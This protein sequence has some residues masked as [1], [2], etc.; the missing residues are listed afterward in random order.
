[1]C[2]YLHGPRQGGTYY[3]RMSIPE[4]LRP[5]IGKREFFFS[6]GTKDRAEAKRLI[7]QVEAPRHTAL[8]ERAEAE[9]ARQRQV[10]PV[11]DS[12]FGM[13]QEEFEQWQEHQ[14]EEYRL[15]SDEDDRMAEAE[16][17]AA[18]LPADHNAALLLREE[19]ERGDRYQERYRRRKRRDQQRDAVPTLSAPQPSP[20]QQ[21]APAPATGTMLDTTVID[22]WAT[23]RKV[24][25]K[26]IDTH[27][28]VARWLYERVGKIP[29]ADITRAH[30]IAFKD[31]LLEE[32]QSVPNINMKLSRL[33]TLLQWAA[34][35]DLAPSNAGH[36]ISIKGAAAAGNKRLPFDQTD[37]QA[38]FSS[39]VFTEGAR[40]TPGRGE[41]V[42]WL[43][44]LAL[45]SGARMEELG[46]L[47]PSD[48]Q[49]LSYPDA[50]GV[51]HSAW[52]LRITTLAD[53]GGSANQ[54]K[55]QE[56]ER[57][58]PVHPEIARLGFIRYVEAVRKA[59]HTRIFPLLKP[60]AYKR[61]TAKWGEWFGPY[62]RNVCKVTDR[63]KVFHSFRHTF[64]HFAGH[65]GM[66]EGVQRD[67]MGHSPGDVADE[68]RGGYSQHQLVEGMK[69]YRIAGLT[70]P[71]PT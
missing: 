44:L 4:V 45:F 47:R 33:R 69:L 10:A 37:L 51:E 60:G 23:E 17:W 13:T 7:L 36:G 11:A 38:I 57:L 49:E 43:P 58:V 53:E 14:A 42:Y 71:S 66:I 15:S 35:N 46:Q 26:G 34:D 48:V 16:A 65:V 50:D 40:P 1:M 5:I 56:S 62:L 21:P 9:L 27:R 3:F 55:N 32:G 39:P 30:V 54:L 18:G 52:F 2:T 19:R 67:I 28:A 25:P 68:Y 64:K 59:G 12:F 63:R 61:L 70:L 29:V 20:A 31:K 41:A 24:K 8:L 22:R 6:L